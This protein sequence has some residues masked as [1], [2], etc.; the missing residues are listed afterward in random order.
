MRSQ[1]Y[2]WARGAH[3]SRRLRLFPA[4]L[5]VGICAIGVN[6]SAA[7]ALSPAVE[8]LAASSIV[9][10]GATLNGKVNPN[11]AETKAYFEYGTSTSYGSKT[12]EVGVGSG[13]V[14]LEHSQAISG[15]SANTLYHYRIVASNSS[16]SSQGLDK[17]F[18]T[19]GPPS[20]SSTSA[21]PESSGEAATLKASVDPNGQ[22]TTYQFEYGTESGVYTKTVLIPAESAGSGFEPV[23]VEYK[24]TGLTRGTFYYWRVSATNAGGK[25]SSEGSSFLSSL[26]PGI[27]VSAVSGISRTGA[28]L[29]A[30]IKPWFWA[31]K[32]W[33]EYGTTTSY[34]SK[35]AT[36]E[37][38]AGE[39]V[40]VS[41]PISGLKPNTLYHYRVIAENA[42]GTH[43]GSDQ[44]FTTLASVTLDQKGGFQL[45]GG[46]PLKAFSTNFTFSGES[47]VHSCT[48]TELSG[49]VKENP[50]AV[51]AV[52]ALKMQSGE[53]AGCTWKPSYSIK[54]S[55][56]T[57]GITIDYA[58]DGAGGGVVQTSKFALVQ[59]VYYEKAIKLAECEYNLV[60]GGSFKTSA[61]LELTLSGKTEV[62]KGSVYCPGAESV[63]GNFAVTNK[64]IAV[65]AT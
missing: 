18:T 43:T 63:T 31:T 40:A 14:T 1:G 25:V 28:T 17:T 23:A 7:L 15:L 27:E 6:A 49:E 21:T 32:Y 19:A 54:Y 30:T 64:G 60:L 59:T 2:V 34:G 51:Q 65:E 10:K 9:E 8:T 36:K 47:G 13:A 3:K 56:P 45:G 53:G 42:Q 46:S 16:G 22:S 33:F 58:K 62:V 50:G 44:T 26:Q 48:E 11:G 29:N 4:I 39:G 52:N 55:T 41:A 37:V 24:I 5:A 57:S 61:A 20:I 35:T 38:S 12:A